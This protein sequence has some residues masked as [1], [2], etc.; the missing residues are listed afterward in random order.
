MLIENRININAPLSFD[1][2]PESLLPSMCF[3]LSGSCFFT[4]L[5]KISAARS[6]DSWTDLHTNMTSFL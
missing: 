5:V 3:S 1:L 6:S 4:C 2:V